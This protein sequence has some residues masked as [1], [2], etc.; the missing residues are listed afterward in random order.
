[1]ANKKIKGITIEIAGDTTKLGKALKN[2]ED[3][4][5]KVQANLKEIE[6]ALKFNPGNTTLLEQQQK[7]LQEA[8]EA[9]KEKIQV[10]QDADA[11]LKE[12]LNNNEITTD[13]YDADKLEDKLNQL[14]NG[15]DVDELSKEAKEA[16]E[17]IKDIGESVG[18]FIDT[19]REY[20]PLFADANLSAD[21]FM[22]TLYTGMN[23][24]AM[25][26]DKVADAIKEMQIRLGDGSFEANL[27]S[28]SEGTKT[29]FNNWKEGKATI[30]DGMNSIQQ[31]IKKMNPSDQQAALSLLSTQFEDLGIDA[32]LSLLCIEFK[33]EDVNNKADEMN[34]KTIG[35]KWDEDMN[36]LKDTLQP[37]GDSLQSIAS[38]ALTGPIAIAIGAIVAIIAIGVALYKN[39]DEISKKAKIYGVQ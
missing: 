6:K 3:K 27:E 37:L 24:G 34:Q 15:A 23:N 9:T 14:S 21:E 35:E 30:T 17:S 1:M 31:D 29:T 16:S 5:K 22:N 18:D 33:M 4:G 20:S 7:N 19:I 36:R 10:L 38:G 11:E 26:T 2:V 8:M 28:F 12:K 25:N 13:Q 32:S 39:C